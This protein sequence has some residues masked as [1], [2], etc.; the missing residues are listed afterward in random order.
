MDRNDMIGLS[1]PAADIGAR[2]PA[3]PAGVG[4]ERG[5]CVVRPQPDSQSRPHEQG[6]AELLSGKPV[7]SL[8]CCVL[9]LPISAILWAMILYAVL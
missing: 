2:G 1:I 8:Q 4:S 7:M 6:G 5:A 3:G 9:A